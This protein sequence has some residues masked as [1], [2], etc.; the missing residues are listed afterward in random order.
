MQV[1]GTH[2][3]FF[4]THNDYFPP[5]KYFQE[6]YLH[7]FQ[8][9]LSFYPDWKWPNHRINGNISRLS[10]TRFPKSI[11]QYIAVLILS[12]ILKQWQAP[13]VIYRKDSA[14]INQEWSSDESKMWNLF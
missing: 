1:P 13:Q 7:I 10:Y 6:A 5:L 3:D 4:K 14:Y 12:S 2:N 8:S 11:L 9:C